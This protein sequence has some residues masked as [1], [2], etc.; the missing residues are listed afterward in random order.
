MQR[1]IFWTL[2]SLI[3]V[4]VLCACVTQPD[5][6][7]EALSDSVAA[8]FNTDLPTP[9]L[10]EWAKQAAI[11]E[12]NIRQYTPEGT[13][14]AFAKHLPRLKDMGVEV[15]CFMPVFPI[16]ETKRKGPLGR[17]SAVS[18]FRQIN[19]AFGTQED[20]D[21]M[22]RQAHELGM[23]VILDWVPNHTGWDHIWI[24][25]HPE[26]YVHD[27][28]ADT[29]SHGRD[30]NNKVTDWYD[31]A[32]LDYANAKMRTAMME[33]LRYWIAEKGID[34][35]RFGVAGGVPLDFW[36][37]CSEQL[38]K[39]KPVFLLSAS[40]VP[41]HRNNGYFQMD[42]GWEFYHLMNDIAKGKKN[43]MEINLYFHK[44]LVRYKQGSSMMFTSNYNENSWSGTVF[45]R[46]G[47]GHLAF[48]VLAATINGMPL[49]YSGQE[50]PLRKKLAFYGKDTIKFKDFAY[51]D[52]YKKLLTLKGGN[53]ALANGASGGPLV[54]LTTGRDDSVIAYLRE[55][56]N[57]K[58]L[59]IINLSE[60][61]QSVSLTDKRCVGVYNN[62]FANSTMNVPD[63]FTL[64]LGPWD[65]L[66]LAK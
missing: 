57:H 27:P 58:V 47:K 51:H 11:Y 1:I 52:F 15:L 42:Y 32:E 66:V 25:K 9:H 45:E 29:I 7:S 64:N 34:G 37:A 10:P 36:K 6:E 22:I 30:N 53:P 18:D 46:M 49:I 3:L 24:H 39:I 41:A 8:A 65:F 60:F 59:V 50:E 17:Y 5:S 13:F 62:V 23:Y 12:V 54:Q 16:S 38:R 28:L 63:E 35:Y 43:A 61:Q 55:K 2:K 31:V 33:D 20:F 48:A 4:F 19:P 40:E 14:S 56:G 44:H 26:W 21:A